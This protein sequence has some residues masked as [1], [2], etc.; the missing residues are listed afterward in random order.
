MT[1]TIP[2]MACRQC[3]HVGVPKTKCG[4]SPYVLVAR[5]AACGTHLK[6]I[7]RRGWAPGRLDIDPPGIQRGEHAEP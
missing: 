4:P 3:A 6:T 7:P 2:V 5:C 1:P